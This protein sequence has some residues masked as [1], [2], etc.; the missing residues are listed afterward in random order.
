MWMLTFIPDSILHAFVNIVFYAGVVGTLLGFIFNF[1]T[2]R[3]YRLIIQVVSILLLVAGVYFKGGYEVEIQWRE[4]VAEMQAKVDA[5]EEK[6]KVVNTV[7][8]T[9]VVTKFKT[10]HDT[11]IITQEVI[12]EVAAKIDTECK[13]APEALII[14]NSAAHNKVPLNLTIPKEELK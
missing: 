13:V 14:L 12:K 7:V 1:P 8:K 10:I 6:S 9:K 11:K 2:L 4:R 5:A 3:Q